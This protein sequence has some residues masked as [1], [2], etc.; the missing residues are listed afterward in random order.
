M[1]DQELKDLR[2]DVTTIHTVL[3]GANGTPGFAQKFDLF[4]KDW[5]EYR[6]RGRFE[7]CPYMQKKAWTRW[8]LP[9]G[10]TCLIFVSNILMKVLGI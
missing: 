4:V 8:A 7:D 3:L 2:E 9:I 5:N 6:L 1:S 10:V